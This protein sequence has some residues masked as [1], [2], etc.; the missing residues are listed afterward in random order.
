MHKVM[1]TPTYIIFHLAQI[2]QS[3]C[4]CTTLNMYIRTWMYMLY[5]HMQG[6][7]TFTCTCAGICTCTPTCAYVFAQ[8]HVYP[9]DVD[10]LQWI[11]DSDL[12]HHRCR[13]DLFVF[14]CCLRGSTGSLRSPSAASGGHGACDEQ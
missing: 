14:S 11:T 1:K 7:S 4:M 2:D 12:L 9:V 5:M 6:V 3:T 8:M 13:D 10:A